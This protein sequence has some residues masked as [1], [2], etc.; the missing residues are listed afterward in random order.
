M[1]IRIGVEHARLTA[2]TAIA[3]DG[4]KKSGDYFDFAEKVKALDGFRVENAMSGAFNIGY[5]CWRESEKWPREIAKQMAK[6]TVS[7]PIDW[8]FRTD[9]D[10]TGEAKGRIRSRGT[11]TPGTRRSTCRSARPPAPARTSLPSAWR[12]KTAKAAS[13][14]A[15]S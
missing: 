6:D 7:L 13:P 4:H 5:C 3:Y 10:Q 14:S 2:E 12:T 8:A 9:P 15:A 11:P 1:P